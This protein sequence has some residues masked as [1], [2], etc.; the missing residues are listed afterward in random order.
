MKRA[1]QIVM[2]FLRFIVERRAFL[3]SLGQIC[4]VQRIVRIEQ[5]DLFDQ[6]QQV[7]TVAV[8]H[9]GQRAA[10]LVR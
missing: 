8:R 5:H 9:D 7:P 1:D 3:N 2:R 4:D 6:I 10:R